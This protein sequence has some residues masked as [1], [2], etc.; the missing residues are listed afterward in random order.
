LLKEH[1]SSIVAILAAVNGES[2]D[3]YA[4]RA[5]VLTMAADLLDILKDSDFVDF[6]IS[7]AQPEAAR[8]ATSTTGAPGLA[9]A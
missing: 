5:N 7:Q 1:A 2:A 8:G 6:F 3:E 9:L 4:A